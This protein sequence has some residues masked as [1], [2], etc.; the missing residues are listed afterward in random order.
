[1]VVTPSDGID[2]GRCLAGRGV[3]F[4]RVPYLPSV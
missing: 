3:V 4:V 2:R 1:M